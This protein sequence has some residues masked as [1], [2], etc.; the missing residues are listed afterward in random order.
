MAVRRVAK[1]SGYERGGF[2]NCYLVDM[3]NVGLDMATKLL[4]NQGICKKDKVYLFYN[5]NQLHY[6]YTLCE[7][8]LK[9]KKCKIKFREVHPDGTKNFLDFNLVYEVGK[10]VGKHGSK[11]RICIVSND[12]GYKC[13]NEMLSRS[14]VNVEYIRFDREPAR[15]FV[16][17]F[18]E[19]SSLLEPEELLSGFDVLLT[20]RSDLLSELERD[21]VNAFGSGGSTIVNELSNAGSF[22]EIK[23]RLKMISCIVNSKDR[24]SVYCTLCVRKYAA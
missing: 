7:T 4:L 24:H 22:E 5:S 3:E 17:D 8:V 2:M 14:C 10:I 6:V 15:H 16:E 19:D 21:I 13:I 23:S 18:F 20:G 9:K 11:R 12:A 1:S